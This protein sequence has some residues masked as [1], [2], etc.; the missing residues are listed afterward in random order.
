MK[1]ALEAFGLTVTKGY[2]GLLSLT[3]FAYPVIFV[4]GLIVL[5][6]YVS[7]HVGLSRLLGVAGLFVFVVVCIGLVVF[8]QVYVWPH[9]KPVTDKVLDQL[10]KANP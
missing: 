5:L 9:T 2:L 6:A 10:G 4:G 3:V 1:R 7:D 8:F